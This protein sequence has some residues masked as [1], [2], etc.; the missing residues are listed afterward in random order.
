MVFIQEVLALGIFMY[1]TQT[2]KYLN[3]PFTQRFFGMG[4][5]TGRFTLSALVKPM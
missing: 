5:I 1:H 4:F 3:Y 2:V